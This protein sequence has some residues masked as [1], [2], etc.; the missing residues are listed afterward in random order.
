MA[1]NQNLKQ[2]VHAIL[3]DGISDWMNDNNWKLFQPQTYFAINHT[4][5]L[6]AALQLLLSF[7]MK[8]FPMKECEKQT[9]F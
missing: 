9:S 4:E 8:Y 3:A 2:I 1:F 5:L 7:I 6:L